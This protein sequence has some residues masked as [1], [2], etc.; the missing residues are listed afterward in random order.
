MIH[1]T[2]IAFGA[3]HGDRFTFLQCCGRVTTT[4]DGGNTQLARDDGGVAGAS[5]TV[6]DDGGSLLHHRLPV[7]VGHVGDQHIAGL[8]LAHLGDV[9]NDAH[10][11]RTDLLTDGATF[12]Q[13]VTALLQ[14]ILLGGPSGCVGLHGLRTRLQDVQLAIQSI[15]APLD[16]HRTTVVLL[17]GHG[18]TR[19]LQH[20]FIAQGE[21]VLVGDGYRLDAA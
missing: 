5:A 13:H 10:A 7:G 18:V 6:G 1:E 11:S 8:H 2:G 17:D 21:A 12:H 9:V 4:H 16:V 3:G 19:Q 14:T 20:V 15:F